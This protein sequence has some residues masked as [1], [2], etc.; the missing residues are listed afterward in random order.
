VVWP[1]WA[2]NFITFIRSACNEYK[3][4]QWPVR[5]QTLFFYIRVWPAR[6][7]PSQNSCMNP[8]RPSMNF[9]MHVH[10]L[11]F[12]SFYEISVDMCGFSAHSILMTA[13]QHQNVL[14]YQYS[15]LYAM[16]T[17]QSTMHTCE[18]AIIHRPGTSSP[19]YETLH[20]VC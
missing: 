19:S 11:I 14:K 17:N 18:P 15:D 12:F 4:I 13:F 7:P 5:Y 6:L 2:M 16:E 3:T 10:A 1:F 8:C 20:S 9:I